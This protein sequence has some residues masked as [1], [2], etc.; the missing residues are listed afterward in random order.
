MVGPE[1]FEPQTST[2]STQTGSSC[3]FSPICSRFDSLLFD[4][5]IDK[6]SMRIQMGT[7]Y[8]F[9]YSSTG[10]QNATLTTPTH[11]GDRFFVSQEGVHPG[12]TRCLYA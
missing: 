9:S 6:P 1:G 12:L 11:W 7:R 2:V 4:S 8:I 3:L 5:Q 10:A